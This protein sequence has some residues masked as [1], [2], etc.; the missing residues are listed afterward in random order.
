MK[1]AESIKKLS[2]ESAFKVFQR[3]VELEKSGKKIIHLSL[4]QPDF[5]TPSNI[6]EAAKKALDS[7]Y[8]GYTPSNGLIQLRNAVSKDAL[9]R[10]NVDVD[11]CLLYTSPSPRD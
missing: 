10:Y 9:R 2:T 5:A 7:G 3:S 6:V 8:H 1:I 11:P 4:G